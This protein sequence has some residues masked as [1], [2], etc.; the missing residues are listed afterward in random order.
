MAIKSRNT[1]LMG[2]WGLTMRRP[3]EYGGIGCGSEY[4]AKIGVS[5]RRF[6]APLDEK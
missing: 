4:A 3:P 1:A 2:I 5:V 6:A